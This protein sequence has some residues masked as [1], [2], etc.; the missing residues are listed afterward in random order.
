MR[1]R[2]SR[3]LTQTHGYKV[4][5]ARLEFSS[6]SP[7]SSLALLP[8]IPYFCVCLCVWLGKGNKKGKIHFEYIAQERSSGIIANVLDGSVL[9]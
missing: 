7:E 6:L 4:E 1:F 8:I 2:E 9:L 5:G 3:E